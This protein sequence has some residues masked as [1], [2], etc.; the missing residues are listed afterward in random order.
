MTKKKKNTNF[1]T[2]REE[3]FN[4]VDLRTAGKIIRYRRFDQVGLGDYYKLNIY[5]HIH[6]IS[7]PSNTASERTDHCNN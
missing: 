2:C 5:D 6:P 4:K 3:K 7:F 1:K